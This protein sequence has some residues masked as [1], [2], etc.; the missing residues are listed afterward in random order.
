MDTH[1]DQISMGVILPGLRESGTRGHGTAH[2]KHGIIDKV[3]IQAAMLHQ[4]SA[5]AG[6]LGTHNL[7]TQLSQH[8]QQQFRVRLGALSGNDHRHQIKV[9]VHSGQL[10]CIYLVAACEGAH[11]A[12]LEV[13]IP[14]NILPAHRRG[15]NEHFQSLLCIDSERDMLVG[16]IC[17]VQ[18]YHHL[19]GLVG[20]AQDLLPLTEKADIHTVVNVCGLV[21]QCPRT[22]QNAI[23]VGPQHI[24]TPKIICAAG[25]V[26]LIE[27][28]DQGAYLIV[29]KGHLAVCAEYNR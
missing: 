24:Q 6:G 20:L 22:Y 18:A 17:G 11:K 5:V 14:L 21:L 25:R 28:G 16:N 2:I 29:H 7:H 1:A 19:A 23:G 26:Q 13:A 3:F 12:M 15:G 9:P 4:M 27:L 8:I 10:G